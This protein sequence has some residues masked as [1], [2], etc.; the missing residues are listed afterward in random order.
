MGGSRGYA[1][2]AGSA[3]S[4]AGTGAALLLAAV[5]C[6]AVPGVPYP[7]VAAASTVARLTPGGVATLFIEMLQ[8]LALPLTVAAV[9]AGLMLTAWLLGRYLLPPLAARVGIRPAAALGALPLWAVGVAMFR[10]DLTTVGR[11]AYALALAVPAAAG[12]AVTAR[13]FARL[14]GERP[15]SPSSSPSSSPS[16]DLSRRTAV[17]AVGIGAAG[18]ALGW[19]AAGQLFRR[20]NPGTRPL[21]RQP[22]TPAPQP[23]ASPGFDSIEDLSP[24][25]T[26]TPDFY[27]VD[28]EVIDPDIDVGQWRLSVAGHVDEPFDLSYDDLLAF[29]LVEQFATLECISNQIGG[30][31]ISTARWTGVRLPD[32][33][34]RAGIRDGAVEVVFRAISG[35]S[36]SL[37]LADA[38][39]PVTL[40]AVGMDG[41]TLPREHGFPARLLAPG[42]YG[43]KQPKWLRSIEVVTEPYQGY[44]E[45]RGWIKAAVVKTWSRIDAVDE[46]AEQLV[47]AGVAFAGDRGIRAVEVSFDDGATW[48]PADLEPALSGFTWRR[49]KLAF[50]PG[51]QVVT[52]RAIDGTGQVQESRVQPPHPSGAS[53]LDTANL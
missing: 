7:V 50:D 16:P 23:P 19:V 12:A 8:H 27:V 45:Q 21:A 51:A 17:R 6:A 46:A 40:V 42:Y 35:Y 38:L 13:T 33:L 29:P 41:M 5:V 18:V 47:V 43:M 10:P 24:R 11:P 20:E 39:R 37:P 36:D 1:R 28:E 32:V 14:V 3:A 2:S 34:E 25:V 52:V 44:W 15:P 22:A 31:L 53:G 48:M 49:W 26:P 9:A 30:D 4:L